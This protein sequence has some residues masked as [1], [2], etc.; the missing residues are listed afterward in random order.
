MPLYSNIIIYNRIILIIIIIIQYSTGTCM[1]AL[2]ITKHNIII[3]TNNIIYC[4]N[5]YR[6]IVLYTYVLLACTNKKTA[7]LQPAVPTCMG[8]RRWVC[9]DS[10]HNNNYYYIVI[11]IYKQI[12]IQQNIAIALYIVNICLHVYIL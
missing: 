1:H 9:R 3:I 10:L 7:L 8:C 12:N 4:R 5:V 11:C 6:G 2:I